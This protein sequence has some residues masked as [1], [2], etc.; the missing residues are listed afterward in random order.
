MNLPT[1]A[2]ADSDGKAKI[3]IEKNKGIYET[4]WCFYDY[5]E[6]DLIKEAEEENK[7]SQE[8]KEAYVA[9]MGETNALK[10]AQNYL[11]IMAFSYNGLIEQLEYEEYS[12]EEAVYAADNCGADWNEQATKKAKSYLEIMTFSKDGLIEQ[13]E[14]EGFTHEQAVYG[15]EKNGY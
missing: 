10:S 2:V 5:V 13:L 7:E 11:K 4:V 14:F 12:N 9:T 6:K 15:A 8:N 1:V 3:Q